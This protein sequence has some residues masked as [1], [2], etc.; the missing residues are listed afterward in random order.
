MN[1]KLGILQRLKSINDKTVVDKGMCENKMNTSRVFYKGDVIRFRWPQLFVLSVQ[2]FVIRTR[3]VIFME[4]NHLNFFRITNVRIKFH[5]P[6]S[7]KICHFEEETPRGHFPENL[8]SSR[9]SR[10][11]PC[12]PHKLHLPPASYISF[13]I[14]ILTVNL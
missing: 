11:F 7:F 8:T 2:I 14:A 4:S 5:S 13:S 12:Y 9:V 6:F 1:I 3:V 10:H